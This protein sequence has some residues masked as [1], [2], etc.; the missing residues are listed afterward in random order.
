[1]LLQGAAT[2]C[3]FP[4]GSRNAAPAHRQADAEGEDQ[5]CETGEHVKSDE[6]TWGFVQWLQAVI[7]PI[8]C[9]NV[10]GACPPCVVLHQA[11]MFTLAA[12]L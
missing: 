3:F 10:L 1:M 6:N 5:G 4:L 11:P 2:S 12:C 8:W 9:S 7:V